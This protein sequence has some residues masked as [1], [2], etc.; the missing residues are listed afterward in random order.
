MTK[1]MMPTSN[2]VK[3]APGISQLD[4]LPGSLASATGVAGRME[5]GLAIGVR[6]GSGES[7]NW[8][9]GVVVGSGVIVR[10]I[11]GVAAGVSVE[12]GV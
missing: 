4:K 5:G 10:I 1:T 7:M 11:V 9:S 12:V 6:E 8:G 2:R 3:K